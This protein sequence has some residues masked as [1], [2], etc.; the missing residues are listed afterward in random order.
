MTDHDN[1]DSIVY[2]K[3][4]GIGTVEFIDVVVRNI[5][6]MQMLALAGYLEFQA[7]YQLN[8][9]VIEAEMNAQENK[10]LVPEQKISVAGR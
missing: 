5:S 1:N 6:P 4:K 10:L 7:K 8:R 3:F 9:Q 2:I